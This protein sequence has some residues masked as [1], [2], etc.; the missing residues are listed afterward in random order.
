MEARL[1]ALHRDLC[2]VHSET[3]LVSQ[4]AVIQN[5]AA[6]I[7]YA[8]K[9]FDKN[10]Y[11]GRSWLC[12]CNILAQ[13][14]NGSMLWHLFKLMPGFGRGNKN[15]EYCEVVADWLSPAFLNVTSRVGRYL[16]KPSWS[17]LPVYILAVWQTGSTL[18][19]DFSVWSSC[20][21]N[22]FPALATEKR[23]M[24]RAPF[25]LKMH[26]PMLDN[27]LW[28]GK[29]HQPLNSPCI[30]LAKH[31]DLLG[32]LEVVYPNQLCLHRGFG[33]SLAYFF[34]TWGFKKK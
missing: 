11:C 7:F 18:L 28:P 4:C 13:L 29:L 22:P 24:A 9:K 17:L 12:N 20:L 26:S 15:T 5:F 25:C 33:F 32:C 16:R 27:I 1:T 14:L 30:C 31:A 6:E 10:G 34:C 21:S 8:Q 23:P 3:L 2:K 19:V